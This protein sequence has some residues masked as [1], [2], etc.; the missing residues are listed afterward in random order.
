MAIPLRALA[1]MDLKSHESRQ[2]IDS[3][4]S[5]ILAYALG[6]HPDHDVESDIDSPHAS[7]VDLDDEDAEA[8]FNENDPLTLDYEPF[9]QKRVHPA[10]LNLFM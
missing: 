5:A 8:F 4:T 9:P 1:K 10:P 7:S 3:E 6:K 2:S